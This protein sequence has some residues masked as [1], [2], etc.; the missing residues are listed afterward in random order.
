MTRKHGKGLGK[1]RAMRKAG[2]RR[3]K[4][5]ALSADCPKQSPEDAQPMSRKLRA[6]FKGRD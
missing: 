2:Q 1:A 3:E 4:D 6:T 5:V